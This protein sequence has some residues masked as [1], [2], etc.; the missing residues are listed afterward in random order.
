MS[1]TT[2][3]VLAK[4]LTGSPNVYLQVINSYLTRRLLVLAILAFGL[5]AGLPV[6]VSI[7]SDETPREAAMGG[8]FLIFPAMFLGAH[9][10]QQLATPEASLVPGYRFPHLAV[11]AFLLVV[12]VSM[13]ILLAAATGGSAAGHVTIQLSA[14]VAVF[15]I[16]ANANTV[17]V[18]YFFGLFAAMFAGPLRMAVFEIQDGQRTALMLSLLST[19]AAMAVRMFYQLSKLTE[20]DPSYAAVMPM[21]MWDL[22]AAEM[23]RRQRALWQQPGWN[24]K[25]FQWF[26]L[27][28][29]RR[30]EQLTQRAGV[31]RRERIRL[32]QLAVDWPQGIVFTAIMACL[33]ELTPLQMMGG[34]NPK[35]AESFAGLMSFPLM[36]SL[37][38]SWMCWLPQVQR[39]ARLGYESLRPVTRRDWVVENGLAVLRTIVTLQVVWLVI[40]IP[41]LFVWF[42]EFITSP[43]L[44]AAAVY[45]LSAHVMIFGCGALSA[46]LGSMFWKMV[47]MIVLVM[48]CQA[49]WTFMGATNVLQT[50]AVVVASMAMLCVGV[51][52]TAYA[53][54]RWC[55]IDLA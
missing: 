37:M 48:I 19:A 17:G 8:I 11:G 29:S 53:F 30:L 36:W 6:F 38:L 15:G 27:G 52:A 32:W 22:K 28:A 14:W 20:E 33:V 10:K 51:A 5:I 42:R 13:G 49:T 18:I 7:L 12:P 39:W 21:N 24:T 40:Q 45:L 23:R 31:G 3:L 54:R 4:R 50:N 1:A 34:A 16:M 43:I 46:S 55:R 9:L 47:G 2:D 35:T 26:L 44:A 41:I 25:R